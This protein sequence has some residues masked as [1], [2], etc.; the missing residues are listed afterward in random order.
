MTVADRHFETL[1]VAE[2]SE[3]VALLRLNR[4]ERLNALNWT[5]VD[6]LYA[7][8]ASLGEDSSIRVV[9][10]TGEGR[11]FCSGLDIKADDA[12]GF[13]DDLV[14]VY[15]R[16]EAVAGLVLALRGM[17][18]PVIAAING[19]AA[20][21]GLALALAADMRICVPDATLNVAFVRIGL[22]GCD[23]GVSHML[24]RIVGLGIAAEMMLTGRLVDATEAFRTGLANRVVDDEE[25]LT[26]AQE[27]AGEIARNSPFGIRMTKQVLHRN[28]DAQ[29]IEAAIEL[30]NRTQILAT[31]SDDAQEALSAF[32]EKR[33]PK[34]SNR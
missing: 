26:A 13:D 14:T 5:M 9:V 12:L 3:G 30:E 33:V 23:I 1:E 17:P 24:P 25:L 22:S 8:I 21:G 20:G 29:S 32:K 19:P 16:Q 31:R 10:L 4:P 7:A 2:L 15:G 6:E 11:G 28:V 27:L 18:Q 34:F